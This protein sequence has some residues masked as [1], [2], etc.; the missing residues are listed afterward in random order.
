MVF[1]CTDNSQA[2][3]SSDSPSGVVFFHSF[4]LYSKRVSLHLNLE[5]QVLIG[6]NI[7]HY[8]PGFG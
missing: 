3:L 2:Y 1:P 4:P 6:G 5:D 8:L 7:G